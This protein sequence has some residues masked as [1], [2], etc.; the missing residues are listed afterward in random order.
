MMA[1]EGKDT[2]RGRPEEAAKWALRQVYY[3]EKTYFLN[4]ARYTASLADLRAGDIKVPGFKWP[5]RI[6][7][8]RSQW[9]AWLESENGQERVWINQEGLVI[10]K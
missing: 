6:E 10:K 4:H 9:E 3:K 1:G 2:F 8:T 7:A 5:P